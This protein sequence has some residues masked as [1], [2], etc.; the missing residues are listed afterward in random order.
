VK[1]EWP[2]LLL[3]LFVR[4]GYAVLELDNRG[5]SN[6]ERAF[7]LPL[8]GR[9]GDVE[10]QDQ[11]R[12][13]R[14]LAGLDGI[15][16]ERIGVFG[17]SYGGY[18]TLMCLLEAPEVFNAGVAVAPVT[19]WHLYDSHYTERYLGTPEGN[20][21]GYRDS[22]VVTRAATLRNPLLLI[23]GM[24]DDNVLFTH[25]TRLMSALQSANR[26]FELMAY[27]GSRH[28]LQERTVSIHRFN[29]LFDFFARHL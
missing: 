12:G 13:A 24:A 2:P 20:P 6:R 17:H 27:P 19:D 14:L 26:P 21:T 5:S 11:L 8:H 23:H 4:N 29:L 7:E 1:N 3:Q 18:M 10:V 15:D 22:D 9:L 25:T 28:A 16:G